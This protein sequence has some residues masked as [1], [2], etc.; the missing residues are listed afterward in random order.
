[1]DALNGQSD[2]TVVRP[3]CRECPSFVVEN[4][5]IEPRLR[6]M[7]FRCRR[8]VTCRPSEEEEPFVR[9]IVPLTI[10]SDSK[11]RSSPIHT[12][13][14]SAHRLMGYFWKS[15]RG[16]KCRNVFGAS[17]HL[18]VV[19]SDERCIGVYGVILSGGFE[20]A[21]DGSRARETAFLSDRVT[22]GLSPSPSLSCLSLCELD[23]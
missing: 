10:F 17:Q 3:P 19:K 23:S 9:Q 13:R 20:R 11:E 5:G 18:A 22:I 12:C 14:Y 16:P 2:E 4:G 6:D 7:K 21:F 8:I 1:M 15:P